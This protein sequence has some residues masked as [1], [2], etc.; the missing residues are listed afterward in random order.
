MLKTHISPPTIALTPSNSRKY[1]DCLLSTGR[2]E[3]KRNYVYQSWCSFSERKND[4]LPSCT[5]DRCTDNNKF[6]LYSYLIVKRTTAYDQYGLIFLLYYCYTNKFQ[7][8]LKKKVIKSRF[9]HFKTILREGNH[10]DGSNSK[11][12]YIIIK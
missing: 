12:I 9:R 8:L 2:M 10:N 5:N 1:V 7:K 11:K 4:R 3:S 6:R